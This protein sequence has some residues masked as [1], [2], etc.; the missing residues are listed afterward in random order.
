MSDFIDVEIPEG[1]RV[2]DWSQV[3]FETTVTTMNKQ[4]APTYT[5][6]WTYFGKSVVFIQREGKIGRTHVSPA[7][8]QGY[9]SA[10]AF[11]D[12]HP[13]FV[14]WSVVFD[15]KMLQ[16][17]K[18]ESARLCPNK[19]QNY[20]QTRPLLGIPKP[21]KLKPGTDYAL[22]IAMALPFGKTDLLPEFA[23]KVKRKVPKR[24]TTSIPFHQFKNLV[25][26][27]H[28]TFKFAFPEFKSTPKSC[29][30]YISA[31]SI[32]VHGAAQY[33]DS[34]EEEE[35]MPPPPEQVHLSAL[36]LAAKADE[37]RKLNQANVL[38]SVPV[39]EPEVKKRKM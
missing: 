32:T 3:N 6:Q 13:E 15:E 14:A 39:D 21:N 33:P 8:Q 18:L 22:N 25:Q 34:D 16:L 31:V 4:N 1:L 36:Q 7:N 35:K 2:W 27:P 23:R 26:T 19:S 12:A 30:Y 38:G 28:V 9:Q 20:I 17:V 24:P 29:G 11:G 5:T 37:E 10:V